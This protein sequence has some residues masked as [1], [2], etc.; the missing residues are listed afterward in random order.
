MASTRPAESL[1]FS[2]HDT[3]TT[4]SFVPRRLIIAGYTGRDRSAVQA[5]ID[6]LADIGIAPPPSI[7]MFYEIPTNLAT[8]RA[9]I[10]VTGTQTSG[11]VEP[12]LIR[13]GDA[14][15]LGLGSDHTD[16]EVERRD[17]A[18]SKASSPKPVGR[19]VVPLERF[20]DAWDDI[21][22]SCHVDGR[23]YQRGRLASILHPTA[24]LDALASRGSHGVGLEDGDIMFCGTLPLLDGQFV[25]GHSYELELVMPGL[26]LQHSYD[27]KEIR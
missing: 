26:V 7:P 15:F 12:I 16:R 1:A 25:Y 21:A 20:L 19:Q 10:E 11:E 17:V 9:A 22:M 14:I 4:L 2:V 27:V 3:G 5:H 6:E 24:L 8:M 23:L 13:S 18:E